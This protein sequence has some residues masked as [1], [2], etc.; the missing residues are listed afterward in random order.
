MKSWLQDNNTEMYPTHNERKFFVA[1]RSIRTKK[2]K[3]YRHMTLVSKSMYID[4][5]NEYNNACHSTIK[6]KSVDAKSNTYID[7]SV[8][9]NCKGPIFNVSDRVKISRHKKNF[10]K[11]LHSKLVR[12]NFCV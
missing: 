1:E 7:F 4:K 5:L 8:D 11:R 3:I 9:K 2:N 12:R 6:I 10:C